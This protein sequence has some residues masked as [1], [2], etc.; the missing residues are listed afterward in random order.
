MGGK[1]VAPSTSSVTNQCISVYFSVVQLTLMLLLEPIALGIIRNHSRMVASLPIKVL[2]KAPIQ[3]GPP[4]TGE[5]DLYF[6]FF[7]FAGK[8][9]DQRNVNQ[10]QCL[11]KEPLGG[12]AMSP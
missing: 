7:S 11:A 1:T 10:A 5:K 3:E 9:L 2:C 8:A 6:L 12:N 4:Q